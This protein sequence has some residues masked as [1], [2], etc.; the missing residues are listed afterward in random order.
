MEKHSEIQLKNREELN[1]QKMKNHS[2]SPLKKSESKNE[3]RGREIFF[4]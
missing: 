3:Y 1:N 4:I 2:P